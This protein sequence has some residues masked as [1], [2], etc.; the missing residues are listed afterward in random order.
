VAVRQ[1]YIPHESERRKDELYRQR[2]NTEMNEQR[3][4]K[5]KFE[6][7][8]KAKEAKKGVKDSTQASGPKFIDPEQGLKN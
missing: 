2:I 3:A 1:N 4:I 5:E 6:K 7:V 8:R